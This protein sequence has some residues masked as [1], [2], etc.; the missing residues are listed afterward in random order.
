LRLGLES[1]PS[2]L[3]TSLRPPENSNYLKSFHLPLASL[4]YQPQI[5]SKKDS[6][7][8]KAMTSAEEQAVAF[9]NEGNKAF[10]GHDWLT[11]IDFYTKAIELNDK[12]PTYYSNRAQVYPSGVHLCLL[13]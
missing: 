7:R 3:E 2:T 5:P 4:Y 10:A 1:C 8:L 13:V 6:T 12:E 11:A 9:K